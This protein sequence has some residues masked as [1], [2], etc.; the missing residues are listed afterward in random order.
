MS[1]HY[2]G[3][4]FGSLVICLILTGLLYACTL[5]WP[6][7]YGKAAFIHIISFFLIA[8]LDAI[9]H[10]DSGPPNFSN[11]DSYLIVQ[12]ALFLGDLIRLRFWPPKPALFLRDPP[13]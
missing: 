8:P 12:A 13:R 1:P 4:L 6:G 7:S 2:L 11:T 5:R 3:Q 9:G 10:A